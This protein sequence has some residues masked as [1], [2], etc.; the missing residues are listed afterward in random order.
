M[1][2]ML[3]VFNADEDFFKLK[4]DYDIDFYLMQW[5]RILTLKHL[6]T[7]CKHQIV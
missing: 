3:T 5:Q 7:Q 2:K 1:E 4:G 6:K